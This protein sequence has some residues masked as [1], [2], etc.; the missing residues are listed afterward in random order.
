MKLN[1]KS[2]FTLI[3]LMLVVVILGVLVAMVVPRLAGRS[4][5][6]R[7][8]AARA[9]IEG[10]LSLALDMY[11]LDMG[12]YPKNLSELITKPSSGAD[13]WHGPYLKKRPVDPWGKEY[14][15]KSPGS[16]GR[17]YDLYSLGKDG[18]EGGGDDV[19]NKGEAAG[20]IE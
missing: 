16:E 8:A 2:A 14:M 6:A 3:E 11:E 1:T 17:D 20:G 10:N 18:S 5:Q 19:T 15:Y 7:K 12:S 9:D 4:E 13:N